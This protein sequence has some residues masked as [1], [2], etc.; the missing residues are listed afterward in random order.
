VGGG[1]EE[2]KKRQATYAFDWASWSRKSPETILG[3]KGRARVK[4]S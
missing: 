4:A 3:A 1:Y 2:E